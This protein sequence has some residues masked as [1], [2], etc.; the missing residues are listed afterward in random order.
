MVHL[1][2]DPIPEDLNLELGLPFAFFGLG[3]PVNRPA[4]EELQNQ[5]QDQDGWDAWPAEPAQDQVTQD[6]DMP[7]NPLDLNVPQVEEQDGLDLNQPL[8][9]QDLDPVI[10]NPLQPVLEG[11]HLE[12]NDP[13]GNEQVQYLLQ[14][15]DEVF[16]LN[17]HEQEP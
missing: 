6:I 8:M 2:E 1:K 9:A 5:G 10:I 12:I 16:Q 14:G 17:P 15:E 7:E 11:V 4:D 13:Q 3:Q